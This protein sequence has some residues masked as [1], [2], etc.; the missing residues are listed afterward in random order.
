MK[1]ILHNLIA[2]AIILFASCNTG[3][4]EPA[5]NSDV[6]SKNI[7]NPEFQQGWLQANEE[8]MV[9]ILGR[10]GLELQKTGQ[11]KMS[12]A[13]HTRDG[14]G[15]CVIFVDKMDSLPTVACAAYLIPTESKKT[16]WKIIGYIV[17]AR[18]KGKMKTLTFQ[19]NSAVSASNVSAELDAYLSGLGIKRE[20]NPIENLF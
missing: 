10:Q 11:S 4:N 17:A 14:E 5:K 2:I 19:K 16:P 15:F 12:V 13:K 1:K 18:D 9:K 8:E 7:E 20:K 3:S 6:T